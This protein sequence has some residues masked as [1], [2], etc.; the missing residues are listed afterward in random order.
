MI[1]PSCGPSPFPAC[2]ASAARNNQGRSG[3]PFL[4]APLGLRQLASPS[5][6]PRPWRQGP[7]GQGQGQG[8][9]T[10]RG[11]VGRSL[12]RTPGG[13]TRQGGAYVHPL[14]DPIFGIFALR[15]KDLRQK[16][17]AGGCFKCPPVD[18]SYD[19]VKS[20][21]TLANMRMRPP[22]DTV[23][24]GGPHPTGG[25]LGSGHYVLDIMAESEPHPRIGA[26][27]TPGGRAMVHV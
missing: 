9:G 14:S 21:K 25:G 18:I 3:H 5:R 16:W 1:R 13:R 11:V 26:G 19:N 7:A 22:A 17:A 6:H 23:V 27:G 24:L 2:P 10:P 20:G 4:L 12:N 8:A 15:H